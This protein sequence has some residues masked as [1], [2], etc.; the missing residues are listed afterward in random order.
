[1][2]DVLE[3]ALVGYVAAQAHSKLLYEDA[4]SVVIHTGDAL[5]QVITLMM[6]EPQAPFSCTAVLLV[7]LHHASCALELAQEH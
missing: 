6:L 1:M 7:L 3:S 5:L 4:T 2:W